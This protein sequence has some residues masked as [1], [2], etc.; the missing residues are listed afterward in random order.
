MNA[1]LLCESCSGMELFVGVRDLGI[2]TFLSHLW[3]MK[4]ING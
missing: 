3:L 2:Q 1:E 4:Y